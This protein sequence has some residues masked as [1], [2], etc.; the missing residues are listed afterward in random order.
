[1]TL[2]YYSPQFLQHETGPHIESA[3][4]IR[5]I[6][7]YLEAQGTLQQC[8]R[9]E[10]GPISRTR[11]GMIHSTQY[12]AEVWA[13]AKLGGGELDPDTVCSPESYDVALLAAGSVFD[14]VVQVAGGQDSNAFCL[15]RPPG[16]HALRD[17]AMGFCLFNNIAIGAL[18]ATFELDVE[19]VLIVDWDIHHGNG[20]QE[21]FWRDPKVGFLS[22]HRWPFFPGTGSE[23]E[24]GEGPG[25]GTIMN[26]PLRYGVSRRDYLSI[27]GEATERMAQRMKPQMIL[28]S[29]GFDTH[30]RDPL[31]GLGL[32][33]E[34]FGQLTDTL[35]DVADAY[36][37]GRLI[38]VLE[39]GYHPQAL[40]ESVDL[41]LQ[42]LLARS[43]KPEKLA[44]FD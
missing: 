20:T 12:V 32:E 23:D 31:G 33:T 22:L 29:A 3:D 1:M 37:D 17:R 7:G 4:R 5:G 11:L 41:H 15:V 40:A 8:T 24:Q 44:S 16:H 13:V 39:G 19:S 43:H 30:V 26:I 25:R 2:F 42:R 35:L 34:D 27:F 38:S 28:L 21:A 10:W 9:L 14:A 36:C 6:P 18:V